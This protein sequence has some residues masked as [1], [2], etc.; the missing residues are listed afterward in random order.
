VQTKGGTSEIMRK[1]T[2]NITKER[3]MGNFKE[4]NIVNNKGR[5]GQAR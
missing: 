4:R 5:E 2:W 1:V 3:D